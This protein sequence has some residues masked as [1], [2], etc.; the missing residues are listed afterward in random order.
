MKKNI[1]IIN[2]FPNTEKKQ[3]LLNDQVNNLSKLG[4]PILLISGC[5]IPKHITDVVDFYFVNKVTEII[6]KDFM[7]KLNELNLSITTT[8]FDIG[9]KTVCCYFPHCHSTI[10][11]NIVVGFEIA[12]K[13]GFTTAF[14][15]ED[16]NIFKEGSFNM[17]NNSLNKINENESKICGVQWN[18]NYMYDIV[19][20]TFFL[21]DI[22]FLL[23][24][25]KIPTSKND[26]YDIEIINKYNLNKTYEGVFNDFITPHIDKFHNIYDDV[27]FLE[28]TDDLKINTNTRYQNEN[29]LIDN[30]MTILLDSVNTKILFLINQTN[31]LISGEKPYNIKVF[32]N[33]IF[34]Y[35]VILHTSGGFYMNEIPEYVKEVKLLIEGYGEKILN[36]D[37]DIIKY[38]G[39][40]V[41][42]S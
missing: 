16:D 37:I 26:W 38:N 11:Q 34:E 5:E 20:T 27:L 31:Y 41:E 15:S 35:D 10:S 42:N 33:N 19:Y 6:D 28:N 32:Y 25:F 29:F 14:Y 22:N 13:M 18:K 3:K 30:F 23:E 40:I 8:W 1:I 12:K 2:T 9:D 7:Y 17:I 36:T 4:Y 39:K 21:T 24:I